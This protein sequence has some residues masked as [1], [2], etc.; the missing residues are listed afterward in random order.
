MK[1]LKFLITACFVFIF[2]M[3]F[4]FSQSV[5]D[6]FKK[7]SKGDSEAMYILGL[8]Y[9]TGTG[10]V[11]QNERMAGHWFEESAKK[12]NVDAMSKLGTMYLNNRNYSEAI[13]LFKK[14]S[15]KGDI[16]SIYSLGL[17]YQF[18]EKDNE[19]A[20]K[21]YKKAAE[22]GFGKAMAKLAWC[23]YYNQGVLDRN[24][25]KLSLEW[26][27]KAAEANNSEGMYFLSV[28]YSNNDCKETDYNKAQE[29]FNKAVENRNAKACYIAIYQTDNIEK[30]KQL[31]MTCFDALQRGDTDYSLSES[32]NMKMNV[33]EEFE[34]IGGFDE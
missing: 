31:C 7:A 16:A 1:L 14:A 28:Y 34:Q 21:Y 6:S 32:E 2:G 12:G 4:A 15:S 9:L 22:K 10:G 20:F 30:R 25:C 24:H 3:S 8:A 27:R 17:Y 26:G 5:S 18:I 19:Q 23:Y 33:V 13:K 11:E 29:W